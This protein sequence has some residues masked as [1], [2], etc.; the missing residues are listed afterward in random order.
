MYRTLIHHSNTLRHHTALRTQRRHKHQL[1]DLADATTVS[2]IKIRWGDMDAYNHVN[3]VN[4]LRFQEQT[5]SEYFEA[6][7]KVY[8]D[9]MSMMGTNGIGII[10]KENQCKYI[11]PVTYPD[12]L[13]IGTKV[14]EMNEDIFKQ[15]YIA[16]SQKTG[17]VASA[18]SCVM[19]AFDYKI[20]KRVP[21]P[22]EAVID[23]KA[24]E[25]I[26]D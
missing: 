17:K 16:V 11:Y 9:L 15:E 5:R 21:F 7:V 24:F 8:P 20:G 19:V 1:T 3:N 22:E 18:G 23:I 4:Y 6:L 2:E 25:K 13:S 12:T 10:V 26:K 14:V